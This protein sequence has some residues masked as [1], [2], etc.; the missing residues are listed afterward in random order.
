M[1]TTYNTSI[2]IMVLCL[3]LLAPAHK[4]SAK[5]MASESIIDIIKSARSI[6]PHNMQCII[7]DNHTIRVFF[8]TP[9]YF[10]I[11]DYQEYDEQGLPILAIFAQH[12]TFKGASQ[13]IFIRDDGID[14]CVDYAST[15]LPSHIYVRTACSPSHKEMS[16]EEYWQDVY[17]NTIHTVTQY[18][19]EEMRS[20]Q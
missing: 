17:N 11:I 4:N 13:K 14:G 10:Y 15:A 7:D 2:V 16:Y 5:E 19:T 1:K 3:V 18:L 9:D 12:R 20:S 8:T 6:C